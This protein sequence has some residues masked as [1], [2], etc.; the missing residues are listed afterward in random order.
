MT[1]STPR[2]ASPIAFNNYLP[3]QGNIFQ[4]PS[5][6]NTTYSKT[7]PFF[8]KSTTSHLKRLPPQPLTIPN[9]TN[10]LNPTIQP[11]AY[12]LAPNHQTPH[13]SGQ[14]TAYIRQPDLT[15]AL[16]FQGAA[17]MKESQSRKT[18]HRKHMCVGLGKEKMPKFN[19]D[20]FGQHELFPWLHYG[21]N[22]GDNSDWVEGRVRWLAD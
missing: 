14:L 7:K 18:S 12:L 19:A 6:T 22:T 15:K 8:Q 3:Y 20:S 17:Y 21:E 5:L 9:P 10:F 1:A 16:E 13:T 4:P 11:P 2:A